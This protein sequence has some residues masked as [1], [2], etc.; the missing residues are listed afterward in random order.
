MGTA[1]RCQRRTPAR[2]GCRPTAADISD[3]R[4]GAIA[5]KALDAVLIVGVAERFAADDRTTD[6][7]D[8][9]VRGPTDEHD[10]DRPTD[11]GGECLRWQPGGIRGHTTTAT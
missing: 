11:I 4:E 8:E 10:I 6:Q 7:G 1:R 3:E 2:E 5:L 9:Y